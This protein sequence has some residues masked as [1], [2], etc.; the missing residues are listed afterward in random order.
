[1]GDRA[2]FLDRDG[3][4]VRD[5]HL[6]TRPEQL[7]LLPG[8]PGA[9]ATL[10]GAGFRLVVVTNQTVVARGLLSEDGLARLHDELAARIRARSGVELAGFYVCPHHPRADLPA[11]RLAC[12]CRKPGPGLVERAARELDLVLAES[13]LVGD[14]P[15]DVAAGRRAG[16][17]TVQVRTGRHGEPPIETAEPFDP[18]LATPD[19]G[20]EDLPAAAAWIVGRVA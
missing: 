12:S 15:S 6:A 5:V 4:L 16:C 17:R 3:V 18:E 14:R 20:C 9:L 8:V 1:M 7:E 19:H 13:F 2:V 10:T 11:Y